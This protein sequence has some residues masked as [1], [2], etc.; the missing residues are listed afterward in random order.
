[1]KRTVKTLALSA[2]FA[3]SAGIANAATVGMNL[4]NTAKAGGTN[5]AATAVNVKVWDVGSEYKF[6]FTN[7]SSILSS[8]TKLYF[9]NSLSSVLGAVTST[10]STAGVSYGEAAGLVNPPF[11]GNIGW[12][13]TMLLGRSAGITDA[14]KIANGIDNGGSEML[15]VKFAKVGGSLQDV[16]DLLTSTGG[17]VAHLAN[18]E[19][20]GLETNVNLSTYAGTQGPGGGD[21]TGTPVIP[22]PASAAAGLALMS[23]LASRRRQKA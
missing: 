4:Y 20:N 12:T 11:S 1:M 13:S 16:L 23:I 14:E 15:V 5:T 18:L 2:A 6:T 17:I 7:D 21:D 22:T 10:N 19:G 9:D 8:I 3:F